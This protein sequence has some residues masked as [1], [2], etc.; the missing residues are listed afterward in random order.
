MPDTL[1]I[2][3]QVVIAV[4]GVD[5]HTVTSRNVRSAMP[6]AKLAERVVTAFRALGLHVRRGCRRQ[7]QYRGRA[8]RLPASIRGFAAA[9]PRRPHARTGQEGRARRRQALERPSYRQA[10]GNAAPARQ[11]G[12][13]FGAAGLRPGYHAMSCCPA[14]DLRAELSRLRHSTLLRAGGYGIYRGLIEP[15]RIEGM[16]AEATGGGQRIDQVASGNDTEDIRGGQ[17]SR[18]NRLRGGWP[19]GRTSCSARWRCSG[20]VAEAEVKLPIRCCGMRASYSIYVGPQAHLD[21]H[22]DVPGC[23][24]A[25]ITCLYDSDPLA[26][27]V[28][29]APVARRP[30]DAAPQY[31]G[32][33]R[34]TAESPRTASGRQP[35]DPSRRH[36]PSPHPSS[37]NG[38]PSRRCADVLR[39]R[40]L[41]AVARR[42]MRA[43]VLI[44]S[45]PKM[46][47]QKLRGRLLLRLGAACRRPCLRC[48]LDRCQ[49][50]R[51]EGVDAGPLAARIIDDRY[52]IAAR[53]VGQADIVGRT[54]A[55]HDVAFGMTQ[56]HR[57]GR[58]GSRAACR[59]VG[60]RSGTATGWGHSG[61]ATVGCD[62]FIRRHGLFLA[63]RRRFDRHVSDEHAAGPRKPV[64]I[65]RH[66]IG[67]TRTARERGSEQQQRQQWFSIDHSALHARPRLRLQLQAFVRPSLCG[68]TMAGR[69]VRRRNRRLSL[70]RES[71]QF[72][73]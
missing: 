2:A 11:R 46:H 40:R 51:G 1:K 19:Q 26:G 21:I 70:I 39:D 36:D 58:R 54:D 67:C 43:S 41:I 37:R 42:E 47:C 44:Q 23:D 24:L 8:R 72:S 69:K 5:A 3:A 61:T 18:Q 32:T 6:D 22:R 59:A 25:L 50:A 71:R 10:A 27:E 63:E 48:A 60:E 31:P 64:R 9:R 49:A 45:E 68:T 17:P 62:E 35:P 52:A 55:A 73:G 20:F 65:L 16:L 15:T 38:P 57:T 29:V 66:Q 28:L 53:I 34:P 4:P 14:C 12:D 56:R 30:D 13:F 33:R 7:L